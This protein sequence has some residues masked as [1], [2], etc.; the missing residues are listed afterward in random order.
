M[1]NSERGQR[2]PFATAGLGSPLIR[3]C[4]GYTAVPLSFDGIEVPGAYDGK[5][6]PRGETCGHLH[7]ELSGRGWRSACGHPQGL[8]STWQLRT[9]EA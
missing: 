8:P 5:A 3:D 7:A 9:A 2:C 6:W 4:P 1:V